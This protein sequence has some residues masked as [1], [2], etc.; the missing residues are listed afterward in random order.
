MNHSLQLRRLRGLLRLLG[1]IVPLQ[2]FMVILSALA[3]VIVVTI[4]MRIIVRRFRAS[5]RTKIQ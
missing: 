4:I 1:L 3:A 5:A 2:D